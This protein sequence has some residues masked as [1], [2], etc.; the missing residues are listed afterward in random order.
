LN[1]ACIFL[2]SNRLL[3]G[4][5]DV[6][7]D[8]GLLITDDF[9]VIGFDGVTSDL[10]YPEDFKFIKVLK[11]PGFVIKQDIVRMGEMV[12]EYL[13]SSFTR[14]SRRKWQIKLSPEIIVS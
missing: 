1:K 9:N 2:E 6:A 10:T 13:I 5:L 14:K 12:S 11:T 4:L 3:M 7:K 8:K